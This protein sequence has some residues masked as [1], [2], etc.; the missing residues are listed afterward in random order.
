MRNLAIMYETG[1][2]VRA[3]RKKAI[4]WYRKAVQAGD[5]AARGELTRLGAQ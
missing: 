1:N 4:D 2:G 3:D 5:D